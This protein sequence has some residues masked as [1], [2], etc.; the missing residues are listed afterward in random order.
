M[1]DDANILDA[2]VV[3]AGW[4]GLGVSYSLARQGLHH[5]V[6]ERGRIGETW[7][8]QRWDSFRMNTPNVQTVMPGDFYD[9]SDPF[10]AL[11]RDQFVALLEDFARRNELPVEP[12]TVVTELACGH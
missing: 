2:V 7:R 11:T 5:A 3:G 9:G 4:A 12:D 1:T 10:G 8:T 6:L